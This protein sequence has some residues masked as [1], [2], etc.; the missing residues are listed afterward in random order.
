MHVKKPDPLPTGASKPPRVCSVCGS[1]SYSV[2]GIH[3]Q[4]AEEQ[5]DA[6]RVARIKRENKS[7]KPPAKADKSQASKAWHKACPKCNAQVHVRKRTCECGY[8]FS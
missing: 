7:R 1:V 3:P 8:R 2:G 6:K 5:A 4:C